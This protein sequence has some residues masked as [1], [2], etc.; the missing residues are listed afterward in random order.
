MTRSPISEFKEFEYQGWQQS[1]D[2]YHLSF[3]TLTNQTAEYL[4]NAVAAGKE[5]K[6][7]DI[8]TGPGYIAHVAQ[9]RGWNVTALDFSEAMLDKA[10]A[11]YPHIKF[12]QGDAEALPFPDSEFTAAVMN[13]GILH[14]AD[15]DKA[16][17]EAFRVI[18][19]GG[20]F[21][22]SIWEKPEY[23]IG[24]KIIIQAIENYGDKD[25]YLPPGPPFFRF[26]D[27]EE[28]INALKNAGFV[29]ISLQTIPLSWILADGD[30]LFN[31]FYQ[32]TARTGGLL[33]VQ[34]INSLENIRAAVNQETRKYMEGNKLVLPMAAKIASGEKN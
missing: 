5:T 34:N 4:L 13:F 24:L 14:L 9:Q 17:C 19:Q 8:A 29:N 27:D 12:C 18:S 32:G 31:A 33:R 22:F 28:C 11:V 10:K 20:K 21:A 2:R 1:A 6:L 25:I 30:E 23:S 7:L 16:I 26:S 3:G 15:P